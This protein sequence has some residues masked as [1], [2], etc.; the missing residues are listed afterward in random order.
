MNELDQG[1]YLGA[2]KTDN[3]NIKHGA[4]SR[5]TATVESGYP[6]AYCGVWV[7]PCIHVTEQMVP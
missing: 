7:K 6:G 3:S 5:P 1:F 4:H 2:E